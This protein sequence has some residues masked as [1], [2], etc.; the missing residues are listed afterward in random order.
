MNILLAGG[1]GLIGRAL[2]RSLLGDEHNIWI[3]TRS[4]PNLKQQGVNY[5][6][7][8]GRTTIGW[9]SHVSQ[10]DAVINLVGESL[11]NWPWTKTQ[12]RR[13]LESR[14]FA[15][16]ALASAIEAV[17][18]RPKVFIQSSGINYY[19]VKGDPAYE[20]TT[21]GDDF[22]SHLA[23]EWEDATKKVALS[24]IRH[25]I[26]RLAVVLAPKGGL[27]PM[28]AL[29]SR[30]FMGGP[31]GSGN[32]IIPWI[33]L[34]D[35]VGAINYLLVHESAEGPYNLVAPEIT[36]NASFNKTLATAL[37]RP[38][39]L[40]IPSFLMK[41][42]LGEMSVLINEGRGAI[43]KKLIDEGYQFR[44]GTIQSAL[45]NLLSNRSNL[46]R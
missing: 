25:C 32:Q 33:H 1:T 13:F 36:T 5:L 31:Q 22:L 35:V 10:M 30:L 45:N 16:R 24:G 18:P 8:D 46:M 42:V 41:L 17:S 4:L 28:M 26:V 34:D 20:N 15:G 40:P 7:W 27:L 11:S 38:Y 19:G 12:K 39:W 6:Q 2:V 43:P 29:P 9:E 14:I 23:I 21:P 37:L 44:Y 3:L